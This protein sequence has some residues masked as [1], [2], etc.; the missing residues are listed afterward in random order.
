[1]RQSGCSEAGNGPVQ[2]RS[3][4]NIHLQSVRATVRIGHRVLASPLI[5]CRHGE[6]LC[7]SKDLPEP[8][9]LPKIERTAAP[10]VDV[11]QDDWSTVRESEF[12]SSE[13][14]DPARVR[15]GRVIEIIPR[16]KSGVSDELEE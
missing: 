13:R 5:C 8:L 10:V 12:I 1:M 4:I 2:M 6:H 7:G 14:W 3:R 16:V 15:N 11:G 9:I